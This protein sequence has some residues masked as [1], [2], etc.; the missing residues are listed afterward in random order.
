MQHLLGRLCAAAG[1]E[2]AALHAPLPHRV[3][4]G[5][6]GAAGALC[7]LSCLQ[8]TRLPRSDCSMVAQQSVRVSQ[9]SEPILLRAALRDIFP[10]K[11][12]EIA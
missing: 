10:K 6:A 2:D 3:H 4:R 1:G 12:A 5:M 11:R 8:D 7:V 9:T